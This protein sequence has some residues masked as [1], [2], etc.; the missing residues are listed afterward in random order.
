[1]DVLNFAGMETTYQNEMREALAHGVPANHS[2]P[3]LIWIAFCN[4]NV[5]T[6]YY[7]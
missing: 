1:M 6:Q 2:R 5:G 3:A 7:H 4:N